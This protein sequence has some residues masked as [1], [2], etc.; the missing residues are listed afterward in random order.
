MILCRLKWYTIYKSTHSNK[1]NSIIQYGCVPIKNLEGYRNGHS[2]HQKVMKQ[3]MHYVPMH[4]TYITTEAMI[5]NMAHTL[6]INYIWYFLMI[7]VAISILLHFNV[8]DFF[9]RTV[10]C[11]I[12][13]LVLV[14]NVFINIST[15]W[16]WPCPG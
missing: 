10:L 6:V 3:V 11:L 8:F 1:L 9:I 2:S 13:C 4:H 15:S 14:N 7:K 16:W 12:S 5:L